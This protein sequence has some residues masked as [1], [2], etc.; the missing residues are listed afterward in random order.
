MIEAS[1]APDHHAVAKAISAFQ[2]YIRGQYSRGAQHWSQAQNLIQEVAESLVATA[3]GK[4]PTDLV[5]VAELLRL[6]IQCLPQRTPQHFGKLMPRLGGFTAAVYLAPPVAISP[7]SGLAISP[8]PPSAA[9]FSGLSRTG[10]FILAHEF[11]HALFYTVAEQGKMPERVIGTRPATRDWHWREEGLCNA[12]ARA[13]LI[14]KR[15][16]SAV[17]FSASFAGLIECGRLFHVPSTPLLHR[18]LYDWE[19]WPTAAMVRVD[20]R[21]QKLQLRIFKGK[22]R[23]KTGSAPTK[24]QLQRALR[25]IMNPESVREILSRQFGVLERSILVHNGV[26]WAF[27]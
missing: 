8:V 23:R 26:I 11:A 25:T 3:T 27:I 22:M 18:I 5:R 24:P 20:S 10:R 9:D 2:T 13:L 16:S 14:P 17:E 19:M 7:Q 21:Y 6:E 4:P 1:P 12:F 15:W